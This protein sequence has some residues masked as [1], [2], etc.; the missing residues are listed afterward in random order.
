MPTPKITKIE[1]HQFDYELT[2]LAH[3]NEG[4]I[5]KPGSTITNTACAIRVLTDVGVVGEYASANVFEFSGI[6]TFA[7]SLI[8]V[9]ALAREYVYSRIKQAARQ[10]AE[11]GIAPVDIALWDLAGRYHDA[12]IHRLLGGFRKT[13]PTYVASVHASEHEDLATPEEMGDFAV[14]CKELGYP[15]FKIHGWE[16]G[17]VDREIEAILT[18][19]ERVGDEMDLMSDPYNALQTF[20]DAFKVG[21]ACDEATYLWYEDPMADG[22]ISQHGHQ[23]LR[24]LLSTP[25]LISEHVRGL[26]PRVDFM[27]SGATDLVRGDVQYNGITGTMKLAHAAEG[28]GLDIELHSPGPAQRQCMAAIRNTNYYELSGSRA[29]GPNSNQLPIYTDG[30]SDQ[31]D[32][33]TDGHFPVPQG[34]GLGV[35]YDWEMIQRR[36]TDLVV[37][38]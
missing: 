9:D 30:Y 34:P 10:Q 25:L 21:R 23:R 27:V 33:A 8:G 11:V 3:G 6:A 17:R 2:D 18:V 38:E 36:R 7:K 37:Y 14:Q 22:G 24:D 19:R 29:K 4:A 28:L 32:D 12:P 35:T 31:I 26:E 1:I 20:A 16:N 13:L 5:Y 15:A